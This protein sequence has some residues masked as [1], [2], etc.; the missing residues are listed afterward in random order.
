M[1]DGNLY[2]DQYRIASARL[3][4]W[5]Y[6]SA[7]AYFVTINTRYRVPWFG[8]CRNGFMCLSDIGSIVADE[9]QRAACFRPYIRLDLSIIMPD[10]L[11]G[12]IVLH[13]RGDDHCGMVET[14]RWDVSTTM[15]R[16]P[17]PKPG[18][19]GAIINQFKSICTK[20]IRH[21]GCTDFSWQPRYHDRVIRDDDEYARIRHYIRENPR[22]W[23][24]I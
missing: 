12:I 23:A 11:H 7:A 6:R 15:K 19:L 22:R 1:S 4:N 13:D 21:L 18:S 16:I 20:R 9:W 17:R 14:S 10:H 2:R 5:D 24:E 8:V 3:P